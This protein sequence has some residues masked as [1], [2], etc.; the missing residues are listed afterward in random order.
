MSKITIVLLDT[1]NGHVRI[2]CDPPIP[3]LVEIARF[4][5]ITAAEA[6]AMK[7]LRVLVEDS[8]RQGVEDGTIPQGHPLMRGIIE[9]RGN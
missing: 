7:A 3:K 4:K 5:D 9:K 2:D 6:Y 1:E 8:M